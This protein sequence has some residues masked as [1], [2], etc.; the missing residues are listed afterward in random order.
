MHTEKYKAKP[1]IQQII[2]S[3]YLRLNGLF[4]G[5]PGLAGVY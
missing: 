1:D 2:L 3:L 5:E 4:P